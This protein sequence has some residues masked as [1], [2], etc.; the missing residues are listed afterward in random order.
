[1]EQRIFTYFLSI[2]LLLGMLFS[3][4]PEVHAQRALKR[5]TG[6]LDADSVRM[7]NRADSLAL[8]DTIGAERQRRIE[9]LEAPVDTTQLVQQNDS[10]QKALPSPRS[11][12]TLDSELE[13]NSMAGLGYSGSRANL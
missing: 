5:R 1:M 8:L 10:V 11:S 12:Q 13:Q 6:V 9:A 4:V 7:Q 2:L 3:T